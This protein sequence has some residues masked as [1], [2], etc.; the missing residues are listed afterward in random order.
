MIIPISYRNDFRQE[1]IAAIAEWE[2]EHFVED[3]SWDY[4]QRWLLALERLAI[5]VELV[6]SAEL[7]QRTTELINC[8]HDQK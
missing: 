2:D 3:K 6:E 5:E 7:E 4:Y 1:L 8:N